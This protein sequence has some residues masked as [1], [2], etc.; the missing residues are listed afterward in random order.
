MFTFHKNLNKISLPKQ[1]FS[2]SLKFKISYPKLSTEPNPLGSDKLFYIT[3]IYISGI[4]VSFLTS[5]EYNLANS[6]KNDNFDWTPSKRYP[7]KHL[8]KT[9][10]DILVNHVLKPLLPTVV[11]SMYFPFSWI[12][13]AFSIE[14]AK[15]LTKTF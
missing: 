13:W 8:C 5:F 12:V 11:F 6:F 9:K 7:G 14:S 2:K 1:L 15:K 10:S 4:T 3:L